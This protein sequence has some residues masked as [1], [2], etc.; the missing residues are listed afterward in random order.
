MSSVLGAKTYAEFK[1]RLA[2]SGCR[3]CGLSAGRTQIVVDRGN[4]EARAMFVGEAPG[5]TEDLEGR[6]FVGRS[7]RLLD[8][9][10]MELG[11]DTNRDA[12]I[13]NVAK[14]RPPDNRAPLP[15]EAKACLPFL[16]KQ[17]ETV[18][19]K[20]IVLLGA[21]A[22]KHLI[23]EKKGFAMK[24]EAGRFFYHPDFPGAKLFVLYHPAYI[25]RDPRKKPLMKEHL[26][27]FV[28]NWRSA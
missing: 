15:E 27:K 13:A 1:S 18:H 24:G 22:L 25:L 16:R 7:G 6:A 19:P 20:W 28:E 26:K 12:L 3:K 2:A 10:L 5:E 17:I 8:G 21:T 4:P 11:F 23:P 14:C 9:M